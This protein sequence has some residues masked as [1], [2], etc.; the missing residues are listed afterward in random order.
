MKRLYL[1]SLL[2][3]GVLALVAQPQMKFD[4]QANNHGSVLWANPVTS[5]F[6]VTN[7]GDSPLEI[8]DV[9][10]SCACMVVDWPK[11]PIE[12]GQSGKILA[13]FDAKALGHFYKEVEVHS[14]VSAEPVYLQ[15]EGKV[16]S[17]T[18]DIVTFDGF[19]IEMGEVKLDKDALFF[20]GVKRGEEPVEEISVLNTSRAAFE[21]ILMHT[22][23]YLEVTAIPARIPAGRN[24]KIR[25]KL[26]TD[27]IHDTGLTQTSVYLS[28]FFGDKVNADNEVSVMVLLAPESAQQQTDAVPVLELASNEV[29]L[30]MKNKPK[31]K[32]TVLLRNSGR[33]VL[34]IDRLQLLS[35][36]LNI[37]IPKKDIQ[38]GES[39]KMK[40]A[41]DRTKL[42]GGRQPRVLMIT[43]DP[44]HSAE[45]ITFKME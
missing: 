25:V 30:F 8:N 14:N 1:F 12:P 38:P 35:S 42:S 13:V 11:Q 32:A 28:R 39:I 5:V 44:N 26:L 34:R 36:A 20:R 21:P 27:K 43:N 19:D 29:T 40:I 45:M 16:V 7:V 37:S 22:P 33:A 31:G 4:K 9:Q 2:L 15:M 23:E 41:L 10:T 18:D 24:G 3:F 17:S 6:Q